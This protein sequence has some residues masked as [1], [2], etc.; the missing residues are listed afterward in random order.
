MEKDL[1]KKLDKVILFVP[2]AIMNRI[3]YRIFGIS[4]KFRPDFKSGL[5]FSLVTILDCTTLF[6][7]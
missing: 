7:V 4:G 5:E 2:L 3:M 1:W 6:L